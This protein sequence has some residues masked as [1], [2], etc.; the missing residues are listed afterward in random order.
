MQ[1]QNFAF[2]TYSQHVDGG[3]YLKSLGIN[4]WIIVKQILQPVGVNV[5]T[6]GI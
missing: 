5:P 2:K 4:T 6:I 3:D 1:T